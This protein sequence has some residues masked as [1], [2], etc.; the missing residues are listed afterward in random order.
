[1]AY[2]EKIELFRNLLSEIHIKKYTQEE[3]VK[4]VNL[5]YQ[6]IFRGEF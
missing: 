5:I 1:M 4:I 2:K 6:D 3:Y